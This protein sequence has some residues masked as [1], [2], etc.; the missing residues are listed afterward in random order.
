VKRAYLISPFSGDT[1]RNVAYALRAMHH[2]LQLGYSPYASHILFAASGALDDND[3]KDRN[4]GMAAGYAFLSTCE[5]AFSFMDLGVS[6]GMR[7]DLDA[8]RRLTV[9][10]DYVSLFGGVPTADMLHHLAL[11]HEHMPC[12][13]CQVEKE[14]TEFKNG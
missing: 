14:R 12:A 2:C 7:A 13:M 3:E 8:A 5:V 1:K 4:F 11:P 10:I 9:R 6:R